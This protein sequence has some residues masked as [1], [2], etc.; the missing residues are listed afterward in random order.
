MYSVIVPT[1]WKANMDK[2][3]D[4]LSELNKSENIIEIILIDNDPTVDEELKQ[5]V[6][7]NTTKVKHLRMDRNIYVNPAWNLG[8]NMALGEYLVFLNDDVWCNPSI[9][10]I[11]ELHKKHQDK[12]NGIYGTSTECFFCKDINDPPQVED[13][14][15]KEGV[16][17]ND[18]WGCMFIWKR[19]KWIDIPNDLLVFYGDD[20]IVKRFLANGGRIYLLYNICITEWAQTSRS[21]IM[22][23]D[24]I[25]Y[26]SK[27][28]K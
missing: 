6:L 20:Y 21:V 9:N 10:N 17:R 7:H 1:L 18:G 24:E 27:Y 23:N 26:N 22:V 2:F 5:H 11:F 28:I 14:V 15:Y 25:N 19:D 13:M 4:T 16:G 3:K 8:A 12:E